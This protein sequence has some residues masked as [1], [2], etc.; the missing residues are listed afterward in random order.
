MKKLKEQIKGQ[1]ELLGESSM[2]GY[3]LDVMDLQAFAN[4][5]TAGSLWEELTEGNKDK[6]RELYQL[7]ITNL[8]YSQL[9]FNRFKDGAAMVQMSLDEYLK[10]IS[11]NDYVELVYRDFKDMELDNEVDAAMSDLGI[12]GVE[13]IEE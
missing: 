13:D 7:D 5:I 6:V 2:V 9:I 8:T 12:N 1:I 11:Y 3:Q 4:K 10:T